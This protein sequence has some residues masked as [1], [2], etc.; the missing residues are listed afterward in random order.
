MKRRIPLLLA[1]VFT[2]TLFCSAGVFAVNTSGNGHDDFDVNE[3]LNNY[4]FGWNIASSFT[5]L[6]NDG[7]GSP[8]QFTDK[9]VYD[10][11]ASGIKVYI[12]QL[13]AGQL[14][15]VEN[16]EAAVKQERLVEVKIGGYYAENSA[17][18]FGDG[19]SVNW[20]RNAGLIIVADRGLS[21]SATGIC[22]NDFYGYG[23]L[24][25][26]RGYA[27]GFSNITNH[28]VSKVLSITPEMLKDKRV[29]H[30]AI[31]NG[32]WM[33]FSLAKDNEYNV[34]YKV[35]NENLGEYKI[36]HVDHYAAGKK[37]DVYR[38]EDRSA[39]TFDGWY[40][41]E[42]L[43]DRWQTP[44]MMP[45]KDI[46]VYGKYVP[47]LNKEDHFNYL[48]GYP[49]GT[50]HPSSSITRA[51]ATTLFFRLLKEDKR[52]KNLCDTNPFS[53]V[54]DE[55]FSS[56]V[57]TLTKIGILSGY[58]DGS[59]RPNQPITRAEMA[60]II[61]KFAD[62]TDTQKTFTDIK[63]HWAQSYIELAAGNGWIN[64]YED[65]SFRPQ[66]KI[67]RAETVAMINRV[68]D[69]VPTKDGY[70][71]SCIQTFADCD[72][73]EWYYRPIEEATNAHDYVRINDDKAD[74]K[75]IRLNPNIDW[76]T[77]ER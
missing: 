54:D 40:T 15:T 3:D 64:G 11:V 65:G 61:A 76:T 32:I 18:A 52:Q 24:T 36:E 51:E 14:L 74:E 4:D 48:V 47:F 23:C 9:A 56:A 62:L 66:S 71:L 28:S 12:G 26:A 75:W 72:A 8:K 73:D 45:E 39:F 57:S 31:G 20:V 5:P 1:L 41:D 68:L 60:K 29:F 55:W 35:W 59:F 21:I 37:I 19:A 2:L 42:A 67:T 13:P 38:P 17:P 7:V 22:C 27:Q 70:L 34:I 63:G 58:E 30:R 43:F 46:V 50:V 77:F 25:A 53:D 6:D 16:I 69:R 10:A 44:E 33:M 49:D